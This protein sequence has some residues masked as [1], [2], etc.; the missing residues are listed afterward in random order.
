MNLQRESVMM[1]RATVI[2]NL[3]L[4]YGSLWKDLGAPDIESYLNSYKLLP[5]TTK[6]LYYANILC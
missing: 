5:F 1:T 2:V 6:L 3:V 4:S